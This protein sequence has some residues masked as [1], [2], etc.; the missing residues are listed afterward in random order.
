MLIYS[1]GIKH[2][3]D[4]QLHFII[5]NILVKLHLMDLLTNKWTCGELNPEAMGVE[6]MLASSPGPFAGNPTKIVYQG[7]YNLDLTFIF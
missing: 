6:L 7:R 1:F 2:E 5:K 3:L 4:I